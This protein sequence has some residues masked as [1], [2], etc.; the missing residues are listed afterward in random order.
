ML[1][2]F[3]KENYLIWFKKLHE[4]LEILYPDL[5]KYMG[6]TDQYPYFNEKVSEFASKFSFE[7]AE[8]DW[9]LSTGIK[10]VIE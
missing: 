7:P 10:K 6:R 3:E 1:Y 5:G 8:M 2:V 4:R 9:V